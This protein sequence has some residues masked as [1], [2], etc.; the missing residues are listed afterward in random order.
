VKALDAQG[1][2]FRQNEVPDFHLRQLFLRDPDG[3]M[4]ELNFYG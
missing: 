2:A 4:I 1:V 3:I